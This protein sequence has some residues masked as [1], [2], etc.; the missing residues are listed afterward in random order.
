MNPV[1]ARLIA[2]TAFGNY[3]YLTVREARALAESDTAIV[4]PPEGAAAPPMPERVDAAVHAA[5]MDLS[6][7]YAA[8]AC[9]RDRLKAENTRLREALDGVV[10]AG[11]DDDLIA[12][13]ERAE[14]ALSSSGENR[15]PA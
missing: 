7:P 14:A 1:H 4:L 11:L 15:N 2:I 3:D 5:A 8:I 12:A 13:L 6:G 10:A 9:D